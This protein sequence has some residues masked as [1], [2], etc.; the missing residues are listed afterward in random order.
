MRTPALMLAP[1]FFALFSGSLPTAAIAA[2]LANEAA[3]GSSFDVLDGFKVERVY[4]VPSKEQGSWVAMTTDDYGRLY[5]SDQ[6]GKLYRVT[7]P[8]ISGGD[9][10]IEAINVEIGQAH[11]LLYAFDS[12]YVMVNGK[13][14][15]LYRVQDTDGDDQLDHVRLLR[16]IKGGG[17]HGP[18]AIVLSPDKQS[19]YVCA[20]NHTDEPNAESSRVPRNWGEDQLLPRQWDARGHAAGKLAP[21]GWIARTDA[22]GKSFE[23]ITTG[24]RNEYD[25]AFSP[26]G[27]LFTYDADMEWDIGTP[28]YRPTRVNHCTSGAEFGWR[29]GTGKWPADYPDSLGSVIDIGPGSP[30]G[31]AFGTGAN[32]P[33]KYQRALFISDWS[34][35]VLYAIHLTPDGATY[36]GERESFVSGSPL[37]LTDIVVNPVDHALYFTTGGRR[38]QSGL[39][40]VTYV[41]DEM[42]TPA[43]PDTTNAAERHTRRKLEALH[44]ADA[45]NAVQ[46]A[47][48]YLGA[49]DRAIRYAARIAIEHQPLGEWQEKALAES[50]PVARTQAIIALARCGKRDPNLLKKSLASL[51]KTTWQS[52]SD[53]QRVDTMRAMALCLI[54]LGAEDGSLDKGTKAAAA[55]YLS[56]HFPS[57][58]YPVDRELSRILVYLQA[59]NTAARVV[60]LLETSPNQEE[61][62][63][64]AYVL[65]TLNQSWSHDLR[66][67]YFAWFN[68]AKASQRGGA[69]FGGFLDNIRSEAVKLLSD[70]EKARLKPILEAEPEETELVAVSRTKHV[71]DWQVEDLLSAANEGMTG[72]NYEKGKQHFTDAGCYKCHRYASTGGITGPDLTAAGTRFDNRAMLE[73]IIHPSKVIS[74]QYQATQYVLDDGRIVTGRVVNMN[75]DSLSVMEN[76]LDPG[77]HTSVKRSSV[78]EMIPSAL[79]MMPTG[80]LNTFEKEEILDLLAFVRSGANPGHAMFAA[81]GKQKPRVL[82]L[83]QSKGFVHSSV[84]RQGER[85]PAELAMMQLARDTGEFRVVCTQNAELDITPENLK[86]Y[87]VVMFYTSGDLPIRDENL[88]HFLGEWLEQKGH[89]FI[90]FHSATDTY[91]DTELYWNISGGT[92]NGHPWGANS[93]VTI[94]VHDTEHPAM[95]PFGKSFEFQDEIY[96]YNHWQPDKC[97]VLMSLDMEHTEIKRPYHVPVAWCKQV[98]DGRVYVNNLG[99]REETWQNEKFLESTL[100]AIQWVAGNLEG[101]ATPNPEVSAAQ[102]A[103][104]KK[105]GSPVKAK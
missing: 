39:Y 49:P 47:W 14:S 19:L 95:R 10:K 37:P 85:A 20:G 80:L 92:F 84:R 55:E 87:D 91:K 38:V 15:G 100:A 6:Y 68:D 56:S 78:K 33:Q 81:T 66:E 89:G 97:R 27:E 70:D 77:Q 63:H 76:M 1:L 17:E 90:G 44:H 102:H 16:A 61:Q 28:W 9:I 50:D 26:E 5:T 53:S 74:D 24:F 101:D 21:G 62:I 12:L 46:Q 41:G 45:E 60:E 34:Y 25:I 73:S 11:G 35:G 71:K 88:R 98:G 22:E 31:I 69:S 99:H 3:P 72:R 93:H 65:R 48:P 54:R 13:G 104:S 67:R 52:Q 42:T 59:P 30:T 57:G 43:M 64:Y 40:R 105:H 86:N 58:R 29:S 82:F 94:S 8:A 32:F 23:L 51:R 83:T 4:S 103:H 75:G 18:H 2:D 36:T 7:P 96:Q 79:S